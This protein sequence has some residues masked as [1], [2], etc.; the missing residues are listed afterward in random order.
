MPE[1]DGRINARHG[2]SAAPARFNALSQGQ[3]K[4]LLLCRALV[5]CPA[6][7][8][9]DEVCQGLDPT[10]RELAL[11]AK[12]RI[13]EAADV[14][15]NHSIDSDAAATPESS[16]AVEDGDVALE[17]NGRLSRV[18]LVFISHHPDEALAVGEVVTHAVEIER[19][20]IVR[21][22]PVVSSQELALQIERCCAMASAGV[23]PPS[24][25]P[26]VRRSSRRPTGA[27]GERWD[28]FLK[29]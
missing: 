12:V 6:V 7:L 15:P 2:A 18:S 8:V 19:G 26:A 4:L 21:Q 9:L 23:P 14:D 16:R 11:Q 13:V 22:G 27:L 17:P 28:V 29:E 5:A 1:G 25:L 3:Q 20:A 10:N 24:P